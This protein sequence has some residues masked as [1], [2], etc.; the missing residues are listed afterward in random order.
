MAR[1][2]DH[3][4][5]CGEA[6]GPNIPWPRQCVH[7][8]AVNRRFP[9]PVVVLLVPVEDGL[10]AIRRGV[11]PG[12]GRVAL[13]GGIIEYH[14]TWQEAG[15]RELMEETGVAVRPE[16]IAP[17]R[18]CSTTEGDGILLVFGRVCEQ[19]PPELPVFQ[20]THEVQE[21]LVLREAVEMA[22]PLHRQVAAEFLG[23]RGR[24]E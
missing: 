9:L 10:V 17:Y 15:A 16:A 21:R 11:N 22:F 23:R 3:C 18:V 24:G 19:I 2:Y 6:F 7:C 5:A 13:P 14:E 20:P 12:K 1:R 4:T 8:G